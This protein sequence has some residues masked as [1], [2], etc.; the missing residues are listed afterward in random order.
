MK[1]IT[2]NL[3]TS[4]CLK[5]VVNGYPLKLEVNEVKNVE[6]E[7]NADFVKRILPKL[8]YEV[9]RN[10]A[11]SLG[12]ELPLEMEKDDD[13]E[14]LN[15]VHHALMEV[16]VISGDLVC[17]ETGRKFNIKDG[18]PNMLCNEEEV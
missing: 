11:L 13:P 3:L 8:D 12:V 1:L 2:H 4:K 6:V 16:E 17:P 18:I 9:L 7:F 5:G 15:K 14:F 10:T